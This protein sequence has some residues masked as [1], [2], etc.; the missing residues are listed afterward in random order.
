MSKPKV[1]DIAKAIQHIEL[2]HPIFNELMDIAEPDIKDEQIDHFNSAYIHLN[3]AKKA[4]GWTLP[5]DDED[6]KLSI[7]FATATCFWCGHRDHEE[8]M[9]ETGVNEHEVMIYMCNDCGDDNE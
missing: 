2:A 7:L 1:I 8:N 9:I 5:E 6:V 3:D 4:L